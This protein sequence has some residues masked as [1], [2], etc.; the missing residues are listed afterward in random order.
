MWTNGAG[1]YNVTVNVIYNSGVTATSEVYVTI[2]A[3]TTSV[4][5]MNINYEN[6]IY[7]RPKISSCGI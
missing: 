5:R 1:N 4:R 7:N 6:N 2:N 3:L